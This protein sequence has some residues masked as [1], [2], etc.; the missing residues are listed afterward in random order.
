MSARHRQQNQHLIF[1]ACMTSLTSLC[2]DLKMPMVLHKD[3]IPV[4]EPLQADQVTRVP[5]ARGLDTTRLD[6]RVGLCPIR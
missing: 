3:K 1:D 6:R 2:G 5:P 4:E